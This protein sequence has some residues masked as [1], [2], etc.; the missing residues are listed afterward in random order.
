[1]VIEVGRNPRKTT[2]T[3]LGK[4]FWSWWRPY[5]GV[6]AL[7]KFLQPK[8][9]SCQTYCIR[10]RKVLSFFIIMSASGLVVKRKI[11]FL[12]NIH[13]FI[14][15]RIRPYACDRCGHRF[16]QKHHV[17]QHIQ[18]KHENDES[19]QKPLACEVS[20]GYFRRLK[21]DNIVHIIWQLLITLNCL[22]F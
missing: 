16:S 8:R 6:W 10:S 20:K 22:L 18:S 2:I 21:R 17:A 7:S 3:W 1:M 11:F 14:L 5:V 12:I 15:L 13:Y 19:L 9:P 4:E